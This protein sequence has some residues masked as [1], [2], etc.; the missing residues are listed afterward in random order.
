MG[1]SSIRPTGASTLAVTCYF[2]SSWG[3]CVSSS[4]SSVR[5]TVKIVSCS[6][7][8]GKR[9]ASLQYEFEYV[10]S[11]ARV[12]G[13]PYRTEGT[14]MVVADPVYRL[15]VDPLSSSPVAS[16]GRRPCLQLVVFPVAPL[17]SATI[18]PSQLVAVLPRESEDS[19][20]Y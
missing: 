14:C 9:G 3:C 10:L 16:S 15:R 13:K 7:H 11:D 20:D 5:R 4:V 6:Q 19:A 12:G 8:I 1:H 17:Q 2:F 18:C